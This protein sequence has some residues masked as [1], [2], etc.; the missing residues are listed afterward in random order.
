MST[1]AHSSHDDG[2]RWSREEISA[3]LDAQSPEFQAACR[4]VGRQWLQEGRDLVAGFNIV[5]YLLERD[6][7]AAP[8]PQQVRYE[9]QSS[10]PGILGI[11]QDY[12]LARQ[13]ARIYDNLANMDQ[14]WNGRRRSFLDCGGRH[15]RS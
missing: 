7:A 8:A 15:S 12:I 14:I 4:R 11:A 1:A 5:R 9:S 10:A 13:E 3:W 6:A 2:L